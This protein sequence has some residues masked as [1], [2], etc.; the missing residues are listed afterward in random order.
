[1][2]TC[3]TWMISHAAEKHF[4]N[5][6]DTALRRWSSA[7]GARF[8]MGEVS[9]FCVR[10]DW[11]SVRALVTREQQR[12]N[13]N[14]E[15]RA[16]RPHDWHPASIA[17][18]RCIQWCDVTGTAS[19]SSGTLRPCSFDRIDFLIRTASPRGRSV[20]RDVADKRSPPNEYSLWTILRFSCRSSRPSAASPSACTLVDA[21]RKTTT[22]DGDVWPAF[23]ITSPTSYTRHSAGIDQRIIVNRFLLTAARKRDPA[24]SRHA[25]VVRQLALSQADVRHTGFPS[26]S[27]SIIRRWNY[28]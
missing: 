4:Q 18:A 2:T 17:A 9:E 15:R 28:E 7:V 23:V 12:N 11:C 26:Q 1:M 14:N 3:I 25:A 22:A 13:G 6:N 20:S 27:T 10:T 24:G 21:R 16:P 5:E 19:S 8:V